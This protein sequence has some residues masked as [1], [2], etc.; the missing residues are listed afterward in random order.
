[1]GNK[2]L[3]L[4]IPLEHKE[5]RKQGRFSSLISVES[6]FFTYEFLL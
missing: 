5:V 3:L 2:Y 6:V 4:K 1:M